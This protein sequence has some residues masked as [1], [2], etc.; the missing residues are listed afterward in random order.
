[1]L[2]PNLASVGRNAG[3]PVCL[4]LAYMLLCYPATVYAHE[5]C[6]TSV[7]SAGTVD[8]SGLANIVLT[9]QSA[10]I[11]GTVT[12]AT[13]TVR[14]NVVSVGVF[15]GEQARL[16]VRFADNGTSAQV[17]VRVR[18]L[19]LSNGAFTTLAVLDSDTFPIGDQTR[20]KGFSG[21]FD[22]EKHA[23]SVD[24]ELR[25]TGAAGNPQVYALQICGDIG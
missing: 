21:S 20:D 13:V 25:K 22:F 4:V 8:E 7:G 16:R 23:Y 10:A 24:V 3:T 15:V 18:K 11:K 17:I 19:T 2:N 5:R 14:Y 9:S 6:W 1:M 12:N